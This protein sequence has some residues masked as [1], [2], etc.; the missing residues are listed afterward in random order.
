MR[1]EEA[2]KESDTAQAFLIQ[3]DKPV[4]AKAVQLGIEA[5]KREEYYRQRVPRRDIVLLPG[6][7]REGKL[8]G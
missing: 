2:I 8:N 5:L 4:L 7:T 1:L 6:E 3:N